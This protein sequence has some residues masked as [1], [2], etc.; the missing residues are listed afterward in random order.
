M[1][2]IAL[3]LIG[4]ACLSSSFFLFCLQDIGNIIVMSFIFAF[5]FILF[6]I[7]LMEEIKEKNKLK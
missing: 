7:L 4:M 6:L 1:K 5:S 3:I 2:N